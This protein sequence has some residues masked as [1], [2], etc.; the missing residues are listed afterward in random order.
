MECEICQKHRT[1]LTNNANNDNNNIIKIIDKSPQEESKIQFE[2]FRNEIEKNIFLTDFSMFETN[3]DRLNEDIKTDFQGTLVNLSYLS[4][5]DEGNS[6]CVKCS[7]EIAN[8]YKDLTNQEEIEENRYS[9]YINY[10]ETLPATDN[11]L[12]LEIFEVF[13]SI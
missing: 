9:K 11:T 2:I 4:S 8:N 7:A 3:E 1:I 10:L 13:I 5:P 12:D 6:I